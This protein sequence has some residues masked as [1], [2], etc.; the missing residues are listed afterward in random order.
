LELQKRQSAPQNVDVLPTLSISDIDR[1]VVRVPIIQGHTG[2]TYV[3][4][5]EQ[6]TN[7]ITYFRC[8]LNTFDLPNE[9]KPYLPLFV[10]ILT[11]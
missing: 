3:Q 1:K 4:L 6:P 9:L 8:L 5:C 10:N 2:N 11:K 7:G